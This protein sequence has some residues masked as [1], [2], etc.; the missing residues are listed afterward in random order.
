MGFVMKQILHVHVVTLEQA[1]SFSSKAEPPHSLTAQDL[2]IHGDLPRCR[3]TILP[4]LKMY[5]RQGDQTFDMKIRDISLKCP[6]EPRKSISVNVIK[7]SI[8]LD[9][10]IVD[11]VGFLIYCQGQTTKNVDTG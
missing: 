10:K 2:G 9:S 4:Q 3:R 8:A 6:R 1:S 7:T 11:S 5:L